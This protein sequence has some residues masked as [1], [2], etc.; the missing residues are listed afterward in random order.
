M[1]KSR[2]N[3]CI[4]KEASG[5]EECLIKGKLQCHTELK[6][7]I[8]FGAGF[9]SALIPALIGIFLARFDFLLFIIALVGWIGYIIF[10]F[11]IWESRVLCSHCPN[12]ANDSQKTLR[13][14][15]NAGFLKTAKYHPG[16]MT[17]S[18]KIQFLAG[19][20]ILLGYPIPFLI[21]G[22]QYLMLTL[23]I[24][25]IILLITVLQAIICPICVNFSCPLN[26]VPKKIR[27]NFLKRNPEMRTAW[28]KSG[29]KID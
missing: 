6:Y 24:F 27:D 16:P 2:H 1:K 23:V 18:E 17:R 26:R 8:Y 13:C 20:A 12:Y 14:Y 7:S 29:Y 11:L 19:V 4:W 9:F 21:F 15:A 28:E 10:F 22:K 25:G 5:C 3:V